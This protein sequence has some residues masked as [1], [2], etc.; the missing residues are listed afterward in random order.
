METNND[1]KS[2]FRP[3]ENAKNI[4]SKPNLIW[5]TDITEYQ[6]TKN[7]NYK[8]K[9][10]II[11]DHFSNLLIN[12]SFK[13]NGEYN[14]LEAFQFIENAIKNTTPPIKPSNNSKNILT[15]FIDKADIYTSDIF[16][17]NINKLINQK[18]VKFE[19]PIPCSPSQ[20]AIVERFHRTIKEFKTLFNNFE[21]PITLKDYFLQLPE[22]L[23]DQILKEKI[24]DAFKQTYNQYAKSKNNKCIN[25]LNIEETHHGAAM[26]SEFI[27]EQ[28]YA[29]KAYSKDIVPIH[30]TEFEHIQEF[31]SD[32]LDIV[33]EFNKLKPTNEGKAIFY[34]IL[35]M[36][37]RLENVI[38]TNSQDVKEEVQGLGNKIE[39]G[40]QEI[41]SLLI[42]QNSIPTKAYEMSQLLDSS[43]YVFFMNNLGQKFEQHTQVR[44]SQLKIIF[45]LLYFQGMKLNEIHLLTKR[46]I[47]HAMKT[48]ELYLFNK[49]NNMHAQLS[50]SPQLINALKDLNED[51]NFVFTVNQ[52]QYLGSSFRNICKPMDNNNFL[53][54]VNNEIKRLALARGLKG[55]F[56]S[57]SIRAGYIAQTLRYMDLIECMKLA[58]H[59]DARSTLKYKRYN[60]DKEKVKICFNKAYYSKKNK[61]SI[62]E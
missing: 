12:H 29:Q 28:A 14:N 41:K 23:S 39:L 24:Q 21:Q 60:I 57:H 32:M 25:T 61:L 8:I 58:N 36:Q 10:M 45:C 48:G 50:L 15:I 53:R 26:A 43:H 9:A 6:V 51:I 1:I 46:N 16:R 35:S 11:I 13:L 27:G 40:N 49:K 62:K 42:K 44:T 30:N 7:K 34:Q 17:T 37:A 55:K 4:P 56:T 33:N 52:F 18:I 2:Y 31:K 38:K 5:A 3:R 59:K 47:L 22:Q 20:N 54:F 19:H